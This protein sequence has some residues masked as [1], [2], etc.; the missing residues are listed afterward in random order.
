MVV[1][2]AIMKTNKIGHFICGVLATY[3]LVV[4]CGNM[5]NGKLKNNTTETELEDNSN[6]KITSKKLKSKGP[7]LKNRIGKKGKKGKS[8]KNCPCL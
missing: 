6:G 7:E 4:A 8:N 3:G 5:K 1:E 2:V